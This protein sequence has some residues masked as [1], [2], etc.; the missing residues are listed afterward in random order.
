MF[1]S[2]SLKGLT[3]FSIVSSLALMSN[4]IVIY[5][6]IKAIREAKAATDPRFKVSPFAIACHMSHGHLCNIE[7][8][9][10]TPNEDVIDRIA[11]QL[12]VPVDAISYTTKAKAHA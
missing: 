6:A 5:K 1:R 10:R 3:A 12:G 9:R 2:V 8:G 7:A 4:H 11:Q